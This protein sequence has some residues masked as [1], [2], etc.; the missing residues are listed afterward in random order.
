[1]LNNWHG[2]C[3]VGNYRTFNTSKKMWITALIFLGVLVGAYLLDKYAQI[4]NED[5]NK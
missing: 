1:M 3:S 2:F 5:K 4:M